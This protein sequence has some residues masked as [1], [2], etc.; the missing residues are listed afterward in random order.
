MAGGARAASAAGPE[1]A[2]E[3]QRASPSASPACFLLLLYIPHL[4]KPVS[5]FSF[6][7][8]V[9]NFLSIRWINVPYPSEISR[10]EFVLVYGHSSLNR[11]K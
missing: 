3:G 7:V 2:G 8:L 10:L 6:P 11:E 4:Y 5:E 1:R 9:K